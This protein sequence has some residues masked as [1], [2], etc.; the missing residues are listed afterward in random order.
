M[1]DE[2]TY[3]VLV[4]DPFGGYATV[5]SGLSKEAA[6]KL[7]LT[8]QGEVDYFTTT[9]VKPDNESNNYTR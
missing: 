5:E 2:G 4:G 1:E 9:M 3:S 6:D 8:V 7:S